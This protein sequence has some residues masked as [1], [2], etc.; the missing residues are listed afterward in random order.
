[1]FSWDSGLGEL[2]H[3]LADTHKGRSNSYPGIQALERSVRIN[4][5]L[6]IL[7]SIL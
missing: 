5:G 6:A 2:V 1:M 7:V 4:P 3:D